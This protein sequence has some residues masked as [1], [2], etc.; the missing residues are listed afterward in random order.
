MSS[1]SPYPAKIETTNPF[2]DSTD[3]Q[4]V[5]RGQREIV[6]RQQERI[7][8]LE[9][10]LAAETSRVDALEKIETELRHA[11]EVAEV[12]LTSQGSF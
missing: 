1:E 3:P 5:E 11:E 12:R 2:E 6:T 8:A 10:Q 7:R 4:S 9:S